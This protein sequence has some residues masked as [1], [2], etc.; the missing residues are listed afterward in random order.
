MRDRSRAS[1]SRNPV[2]A[3][4]PYPSCQ[5]ARIDDRKMRRDDGRIT[6]RLE[7][8]TKYDTP[9]LAL[10][11]MHDARVLD[12]E[13]TAI[14]QVVGDGPAERERVEVGLAG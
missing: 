14:R 3:L 7:P 11:D 1:G 10:L 12:D 6:S 9:F 4:G 8:I 5:Q 2:R 13:S